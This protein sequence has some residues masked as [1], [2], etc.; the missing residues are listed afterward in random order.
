MV[1]MFVVG[2][3]VGSFLCCQARRLRLSISKVRLG[4][5][6]VCLDCGKQLKWYDNVPIVSWLMLGG[7]C[8]YCRKRIGVAEILAEVGMGLAFLGL[9]MRFW[10]N[11]GSLSVLQG[12]GMSESWTMLGLGPELG[13]LEWIGWGAMVMLIISLGFLAIYDG[14]YGELPSLCLTFAII[15]AILEVILKQWSLFLTG[16]FSPN[17]VWEPLAAV[18]IL[19]GVY[20]LLYVV[21]RGAW[22]GDG[23]WLL[24]VALGLALA[25]PWLALVTLFLANLLA[26][27]VSL[28]QVARQ[29][30]SRE[31][32]G[33][34]QQH[35]GTKIE[36]SAKVAGPLET[37]VYLGPY[38]VVAFG[39]V[40]TIAGFLGQWQ[41]SML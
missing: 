17:L 22:V 24:G 15:C 13:P 34:S 26:V 28:P 20:L 10:Q 25:S 41:P 29:T 38:L 8:R 32:R 23:D 4:K 6:S 27:T 7:K 9:G 39:V 21:S 11:G 1:L 31:G 36:R 18:A 19:G 2:A 3:C 14:L 40:W 33:R 5:R 30:A 16:G 37:K 35:K 12:D